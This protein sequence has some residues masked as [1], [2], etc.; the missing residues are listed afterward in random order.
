MKYKQNLRVEGNK[1]YSYSTHVATIDGSKLLV[2]GHWSMT[3]SKHINH[4][5]DEYGLQKE[6]AKPEQPE[7]QDKGNSPLKTASIVALMGE[8]F[9]DTPKEKNDWKKRMLATTPGISFPEDWDTLTEKEK[10]RRLDGA[11]N[12]GLGK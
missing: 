12:I 9:A 1:V 10:K 2:H 5:A 7:P 11:M 3:T 8:F 6:D 4:I